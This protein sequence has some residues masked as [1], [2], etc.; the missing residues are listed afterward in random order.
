MQFLERLRLGPDC[1]RVRFLLAAVF[2]ICKISEIFAEFM[3][4][5][6]LLQ[7]A[8]NSCHC[9]FHIHQVYVMQASVIEL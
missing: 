6:K 7:L 8:D 1:N 9:L 5:P 4:P 2:D 3:L